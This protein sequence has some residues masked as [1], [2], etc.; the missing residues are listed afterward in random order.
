MLNKCKFPLTDRFDVF[1]TVRITRSWQGEKSFHL[2]LGWH[3][4][5]S[6]PLCNGQ[7]VAADFP[8]I[9]HKTCFCWELIYSANW[10]NIAELPSE[11]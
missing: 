6:K 8:M 9:M 3:P 5:A 11:L 10:G 1:L 2:V 4:S 7:L